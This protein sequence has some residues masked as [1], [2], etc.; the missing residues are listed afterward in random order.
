MVWLTRILTTAGD[1]CLTSGA[2]LDMGWLLISF[3]SAAKLLFSRKKTSNKNNEKYLVRIEKPSVIFNCYEFLIILNIDK[4]IH[5]VRANNSQN[6][7]R[8]NFV[9][10]E[11]I[12]AI[13]LC[14]NKGLSL[15]FKHNINL[16]CK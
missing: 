10:Y 1:T 15:I 7:S 9:Y 3:G 8:N 5:P 14:M 12:I 16:I 4:K 6:L 13:D 2:K 11:S